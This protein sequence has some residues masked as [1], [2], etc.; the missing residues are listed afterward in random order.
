MEKEKVFKTDYGLESIDFQKD[1]KIVQDLYE[2][3]CTAEN[4]FRSGSKDFSSVNKK[5]EELIKDRF[6]ITTK[7]VEGDGILGQ[8]TLS[9]LNSFT[10]FNPFNGSVSNAS[11]IDKLFV[12]KQHLER[13]KKASE[14]F[15]NWLKKNEY[16]VD[17]KNARITGLSK[18]FNS[19]IHI[20]WLNIF[21]HTYG[22][23]T[24]MEIVGGLIHEIGH[25][26]TFSAYIYK[27]RDSTLAF[28]DVIRKSNGRPD[29]IIIG[30]NKIYNRN[31][32]P[33]E[34]K[35]A[36]QTIVGIIE[37]NSKRNE[38]NM[39]L[40]LSATAPESA[41]DQ[42]ASRFGLGKEFASFIIKAAYPEN[43]KIMPKSLKLHLETIKHRSMFS[44]VENFIEMSPEAVKIASSL[45]FTIIVT[46]FLKTIKSF[47]AA[48][49]SN[50]YE[51]DYRRVMKFLIDSIRII[52]TDDTL[53]EKDK[54]GLLETIDFV[55]L[56]LIEMEKSG[57]SKTNHKANLI[58]RIFS[59]DL[60][61]KANM[62]RLEGEME[63]LMENSLHAE[64]LRIGS[65][66]TE[67]I[68][69]QTGD[70]FVVKLIE[71]LGRLRET[72]YRTPND[73][74]FLKTY[75]TELEK[76]LEKRFGYRL[77]VYLYLNNEKSANI[78]RNVMIPVSSAL[79]RLYRTFSEL[80][81]K[82][83][84][85]IPLT[86]ENLKEL[87]IYK[88]HNDEIGSYLSKHN[89]FVNEKDARIEGL[90]SDKPWFTL[91]LGLPF[92]FSSPLELTDEE[93]AA[94]IL[95]E[96]GHTF[97]IV[98]T[99]Y[100]TR[101]AKI[102]FEDALREYSA[103]KNLSKGE[104]LVL[105]YNKAYN[106]NLNP[107]S[108]RYKIKTIAILDT[109]LD[110]KPITYWDESQ[111]SSTDTEF[112]AD[113]FAT[114]FGLGK[115]LAVS[116]DKLT[117]LF[118]D[119]T[120][121]SIARN[122]AIIAES[123]F[124]GVINF[125]VPVIMMFAFPLLGLVVLFLLLTFYIPKVISVLA[126]NDKAFKKN[127]L[128]RK[129]DIDYKRNERIA[130]DLIRQL[131]LYNT[132]NNK[133][134]IETVDLIYSLIDGNKEVYKITT[135]YPIFSKLIEFFNKDGKNEREIAVFGEDLE[136]I[137]ENKLHIESRRL[138]NL[139]GEL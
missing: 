89:I 133:D 46:L 131:R 26:F 122:K 31:L 108:I 105:S 48:N 92:L 65:I 67:A 36:V 63:E 137:M 69:P 113:Q 129:Y 130:L 14:E 32:D 55:K 123:C 61:N 117:K 1:T 50:V 104:A 132:N 101:Q 28:E 86:E 37:D 54:L 95:H 136:K 85:N 44:R 75:Q 17:F 22:V 10:G 83:K 18:D 74:S 56:C 124:F 51:A 24:P 8:I 82:Y 29:S 42:F 38:W 79:N 106:G 88:R 2:Q 80:E 118:P 21:R 16:K 30:Y 70:K 109:I 13:L 135:S 57:F 73:P 19:E 84:N 107:K 27:H 98:G 77:P 121:E 20:S 102:V 91:E 103:N 76:L 66:S 68:A 139:L 81:T 62:S 33:K 120:H 134:I 115:P 99:L 58:V 125:A 40:G 97:T 25:L 93:I 94:I 7:I 116:L 39:N 11:F 126:S 34:Y 72:F 35:D 128:Y 43:G 60:T 6:G 53:S 64:A 23:F 90:P 41:A 12:S 71:Y 3:V 4:I 59:G 138:N 100:K 5:I 127:N 47:I 87:E 110:M 119:K 9:N 15:D 114:R 78:I 96:I 111:T 45:F 52:R 112:L 49:S